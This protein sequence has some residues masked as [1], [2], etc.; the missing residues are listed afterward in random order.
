[1]GRWLAAAAVAWPVLL[2]GA[3]VAHAA[4]EAR[5]WSVA[6]Y[7][8]GSWICHQRP[9]RSF[10]LAGVRWPVCGRCSGLYLGGAAGA[11]GFMRRRRSRAFPLRT[12]LIA[13]SIPTMATLVAEASGLEIANVV[14]AI[15]A[16]PAGVAMVIAMLTVAGS[17]APKAIR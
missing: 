16:V 9:E 3:L 10:H 7:M 13:S 11:I 6:V 8:T 2:G 4:G 12:M 17:D 5:P 15:A 1:M 14:R